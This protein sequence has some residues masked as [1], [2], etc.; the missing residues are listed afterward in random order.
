M[1]IQETYPPNIEEI[2]KLFKITSLTIYAYGDTIYNPSGLNINKPLLEHELVHIKQ[3][4]NNPKEWWIKYLQD[5]DFRLN[6]EVQAFQR[7]YRVAKGINKSQSHEYLKELASNLSGELYGE[8]I[9]YFE[10]LKIIK[11]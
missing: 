10:A 6:Q 7:Q 4:N 8:L 5:I 1:L 11:S 2:K 9:T 3:Q